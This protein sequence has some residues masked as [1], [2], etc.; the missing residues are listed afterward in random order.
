MG[1]RVRICVVSNRYTSP[2][3]ASSLAMMTT[4]MALAKTYF[5]RVGLA[6][7][8]WHSCL[9]IAREQCVT[10]CLNE[11]DTHILFIDDDSIVP[12]DAGKRLYQSGKR[13]VGVNFVRKE[14]P[15][16]Y[17]AKGMDGQNLS[18]HKKSGI[19]EV[20]RIGFGM[21][22]IHLD[23]FRKMEKPWFRMEW[24]KETGHVS[25]DYYFSERA[26]AL[27]EKI[28]IDHSLSQQ[29]QHAGEFLYSGEYMDAN[30]ETRDL[31]E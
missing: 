6:C 15:I 17:C 26:K 24:S 5:D 14:F 30:I 13:I 18:S 16:T 21:T 25:E 7:K 29:C 19:E 1:A 3:F 23:I 28:Y 2:V 20:Q 31:I 27:G 8:A 11:N 22:L 10:L 12:Q 9:P 4:N